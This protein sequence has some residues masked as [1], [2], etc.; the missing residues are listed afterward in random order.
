MNT[1]RSAPSPKNVDRLKL[2][3]PGGGFEDLPIE[4]RVPAP[5]GGAEK[6]GH[7]HVRRSRS[8]HL[9]H[10]KVL[11]FHDMPQILLWEQRTEPTRENVLLRQPTCS[12]EDAPAWGLGSH[13]RRLLGQDAIDPVIACAGEVTEAG[14]PSPF[15]EQPPSLLLR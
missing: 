6:I 7:R 15:V 8:P 12:T 10:A 5:R 4:L 2:I 1:R 11:I 3:P 9:E 14:N 13:S